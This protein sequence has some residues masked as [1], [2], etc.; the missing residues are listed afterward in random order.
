MLTR[1]LLL[2]GGWLCVGLAA[3]GAVLPLVPTTPFL[4]VAAACFARSSERLHQWLLGT[5]AFGPLIR[6]WNETRSIPRRAKVLAVLVIAA[7]GT[8]TVVFALEAT[9]SRVLF[10]AMLCGVAAWLLT[11]PTAEER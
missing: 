4:L 7:V 10:A 3:V 6:H 9:W 8:S 1:P 5:R 2:A 11:R